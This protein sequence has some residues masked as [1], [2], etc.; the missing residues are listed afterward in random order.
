MMNT[1]MSDIEKDL[2]EMKVNE[3]DAQEGHESTVRLLLSVGANDKEA[4]AEGKMIS[5]GVQRN[6]GARA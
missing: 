3:K 6:G 4:W 2:T 5:L 1:L